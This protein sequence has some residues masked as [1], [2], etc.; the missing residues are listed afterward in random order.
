[1]LSLISPGY[2]FPFPL[3]SC[4]FYIPRLVSFSCASVSLNS[5]IFWMPLKIFQPKC[6][7]GHNLELCKYSPLI[8]LES[9][10]A[11]YWR[12][13]FLACLNAS[14]SC[15]SI[16]FKLR[17]EHHFEPLS[18]VAIEIP[19]EIS[20]CCQGGTSYLGL[21]GSLKVY[22]PRTLASGMWRLI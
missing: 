13:S 5:S 20:H 4:C 7:L 16:G 12:V 21:V 22:L 17:A 1:M 19:G 6:F 9:I 18:R 2:R 3:H 14:A 8:Y 10:K 11:D 15:F